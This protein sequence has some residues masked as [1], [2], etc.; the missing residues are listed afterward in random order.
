MTGWARLEFRKT[1]GKVGKTQAGPG[2]QGWGRG[3]SRPQPPA[4]LEDLVAPGGLEAPQF[5]ILEYRGSGMQVGVEGLEWLPLGL[6]G[7]CRGRGR[8]VLEAP[9]ASTLVAGTLY[10]KQHL[11]C[12]PP[13]PRV[14]FSLLWG[15]GLVDPLSFSLYPLPSP[16]FAMAFSLAFWPLT[17]WFLLLHP[18]PG[19]GHGL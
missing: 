17:I 15:L 5:S 1:A 8:A 19:K 9:L 13:H 18:S 4:V 11:A 12:P 10:K 6:Q 16:G 2:Q 7:G 3:A 14:L